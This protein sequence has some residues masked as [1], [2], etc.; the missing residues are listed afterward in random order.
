MMCMLNVYLV[1]N[2]ATECIKDGCK[3]RSAYTLSTELV[4]SLSCETGLLQ[5]DFY[6]HKVLLCK[7]CFDE[8]DSKAII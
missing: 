3:K 6:S 5:V 1:C 7:V 2:L 8:S 4:Y